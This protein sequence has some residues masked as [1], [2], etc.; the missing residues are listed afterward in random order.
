MRRDERYYSLADFPR[1]EKIDA[2]MHIHGTADRFMAQAAARQFPHPDDQ[3][4][5][6]G[7]SLAARSA[8]DAAVAAAALSRA[9][10]LCGNVLG[11]GLSGSRTGR[12]R[13]C[14]RSTRAVAHGAVG[15]KIWKNIGMA[16]SDSDGR[17]VMPDDRALRARCSPSRAA[18]HRTAG[19]PGRAAQ[20]LA[21]H[22]PDDGAVGSR[23][24]PRASTV[25]HV[26]ATRRCPATMRFSPRA[27][28]C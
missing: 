14:G 4:R 2:H 21:A 28:G 16:C 27:I 24:L 6:P 25:L 13:A 3:R 12:S 10:R 9:R 1:V 5:L 23:L 17:Y 7:L 11:A 26:P 8:A 15:V 22:R 20:L 19:A 18:S